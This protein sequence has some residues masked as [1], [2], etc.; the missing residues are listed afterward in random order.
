MKYLGDLSNKKLWFH[1][2]FNRN[3][4]KLDRIKQ[5]AVKKK[6]EK[7]IAGHAKSKPM[8]FNLIG[9]RELKVLDDLRV[10][11][12]ICEECIEKGYVDYNGCID[13]EKI[14]DNYIIIWNVTTHKGLSKRI[15]YGRSV[16][17]SNT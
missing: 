11:F 4:E 13:C 17:L 14:P 9:K 8:S 15:D 3:F 6:I 2:H 5:L 12:T 16:I 1:P 10:L 7:F